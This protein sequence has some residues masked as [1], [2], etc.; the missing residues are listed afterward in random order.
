MDVRDLEGYDEEIKSIMNA[1]PIELRLAG[2]PPEQLLLF[3]PDDALRALSD[4]YL[5]HLPAETVAAIRK[6]LGRA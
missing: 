5:D 4:D 2:I 6:R 3:L 1:M